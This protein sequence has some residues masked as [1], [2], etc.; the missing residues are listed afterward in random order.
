[1]SPRALHDQLEQ[2][3]RKQK[4]REVIHREDA[5]D[6]VLQSLAQQSDPDFEIIVADDGSG[7]ATAKLLDAWR[8]KAGRCLEHVWHDDRG[9]RAAEIRNRAILVAHGAYCV[10][11]DGDCI[12]RPDFVAIH[13]RLAEPG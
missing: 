10:F 7:Q 4:R 13:R 11:L 6:A 2:Q 8:A 9:F 1:M 3:V 12:V 5:L